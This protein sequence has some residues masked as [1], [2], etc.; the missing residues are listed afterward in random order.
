MLENRAL[1][2]L[3]KP[4]QGQVKTITADNG[5]QFALHKLMARATRSSF[6]LQDRITHGSEERTRTRMD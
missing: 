6:S 1:I 4:L 3:L 2:E 5:R